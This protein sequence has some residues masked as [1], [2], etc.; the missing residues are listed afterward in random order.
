MDLSI[1]TKLLQLAPQL[2]KL[3]TQA[4]ILTLVPMLIAAIEKLMPGKG[5]GAEKENAVIALIEAAIKISERVSGVDLVDNKEAMQGIKHMIRGAVQF[6]NSVNI[7]P[8]VDLF[9]SQTE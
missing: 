4:D 7:W 1:F 6:Y 9:P 5:R 3:F 8:D 2:L